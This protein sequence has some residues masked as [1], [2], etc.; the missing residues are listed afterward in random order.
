[1]MESMTPES[2]KSSSGDLIRT[3]KVSWIRLWISWTVSRRGPD[4]L[5]A[6]EVRV[7]LVATN[8]AMRVTER[9]ESTSISAIGTGTANSFSSA[10]TSWT[11]V[12]ESSTPVASKSVSGAGLWNVRVR[13]SACIP[14]MKVF[15]SGESVAIDELAVS[16]TNASKLLFR[17]GFIVEQNG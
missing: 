2:N 6:D 11:R 8:L 15:V 9:K 4:E 13:S 5:D 12:T 16:N 14:G 3:E 7:R 10:V 1:M 17:T